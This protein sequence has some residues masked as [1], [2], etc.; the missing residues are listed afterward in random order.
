RE[1]VHGC[2]PVARPARRAGVV[3]ALAASGFQRVGDMNRPTALGVGPMPMSSI[4]G[5]RVS[6]DDAYLE[7]G[8]RPG[9]LVI[10]PNSEVAT[11]DIRA[12]AARGVT[13]LDGTA[14]AGDQVIVC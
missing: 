10:L 4:D 5:G 8:H 11:I 13:L 6:A 7:P 12:G 3:E 2:P 1:P 14:I 9:N